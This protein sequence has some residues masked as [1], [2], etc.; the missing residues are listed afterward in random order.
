MR[1]LSQKGGDAEDKSVSLEY[2][3]AGND[4]DL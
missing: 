1:R 3:T 4:P 2:Q